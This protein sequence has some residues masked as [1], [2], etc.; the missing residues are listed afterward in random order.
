MRFRGKGRKF[1]RGNG[2]ERE[3]ES[4]ASLSS[5]LQEEKREG[6][7]RNVRV[8]IGGEV[9]GGL[10]SEPQAG[11]ANVRGSQD[12]HP[13][14]GCG[15]ADDAEC[16]GGAAGRGAT[17]E[18]RGESSTSLRGSGWPA[19]QGREEEG[20]A[21]QGGGGRK[22]GVRGGEGGGGGRVWEGKRAAMACAA[23]DED[24]GSKEVVRHFKSEGGVDGRVSVF[25]GCGHESGSES[26]S[27]RERSSE[28]QCG[29]GRRSRDGG[30]AR[31]GGAARQGASD[32]GAP[33]N[34]AGGQ[35]GGVGGVDAA[36]ADMRQE[37]VAWMR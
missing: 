1:G 22:G 16:A 34:A 10:P 13:A 37:M 12:G 15:D 31:D 11:D 26:E 33:G 3:R 5:D 9:E 25:H 21:A 36:R 24:K 7:G 27:G 4:E 30:G 2:K 8:N 19:V 20:T 29:D 18:G 35:G 23:S 32:G 6:E 14:N 17:R 28:R